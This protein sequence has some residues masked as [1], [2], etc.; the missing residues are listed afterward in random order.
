MNSNQQQQTLEQRAERLWPPGQPHSEH[1]RS[2]WLRSVSQLRASNSWILDRG[3]RT[4]G[5][6]ANPSN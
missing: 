2:A 6:H 3:S 1:N 5:W 4:P